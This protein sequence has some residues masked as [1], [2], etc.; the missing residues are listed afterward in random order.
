MLCVLHQKHSQIG[1]S[2]P[3]DMQL[4]LALPRVP[5]SWLKFHLTTCIAS[6]S[7]APR[8]FQRQYVRQRD[9]RAY[10]FHLLEQCHFWITLLTELLDLSIVLSEARSDCFDSAQQW[11]ERSLQI[12]A[13]RLT[14]CQPHRFRVTAAELFSERLY[15]SSRRADQRCSCTH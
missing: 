15:Q 4:R 11:R 8:I 7:K 10:A 1:V 5:S 3:R 6:L 2:F 12:R 9:Q 13:Q 14:D